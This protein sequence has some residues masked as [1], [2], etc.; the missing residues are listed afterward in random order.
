MKVT[1]LGCGPSQGVPVI[2]N[3]WGD[4]DPENVIVCLDDSEGCDVYTTTIEFT[5][6]A[7]SLYV[8]ALGGFAITDY[9]PATLTISGGDGGAPTGACCR[10]GGECSV[11]TAI[12]CDVLQDAT[13]HGDG[14]SCEDLDV[15]CGGF[16]CI[17]DLNGDLVIDGS[18]LAILLG[19]WNT[20]GDSITDINGDLTVDGADLAILLGAWGPC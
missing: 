9:G 12:E 6:S 1:I 15:S 16:D 20:K 10:T 3:R 14:S 11:M 2:G 13:Y 18:D 17:A 8:I 7:G 4:C 5:A 19:A